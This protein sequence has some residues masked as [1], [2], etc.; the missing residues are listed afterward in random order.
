[1][2]LAAWL[3]D[4]PLTMVGNGTCIREGDEI[5]SIVVPAAS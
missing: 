4:K 2:L 3:A 1:M 5:I